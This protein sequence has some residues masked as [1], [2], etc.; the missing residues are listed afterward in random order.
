MWKK[1]MDF[2]SSVPVTVIGGIL[3]VISLVLSL[4][5]TAVPVDPAWVTVVLCGI[6][7]AEQAV[8]RIVTAK[9]ISRI[10]SSLLI[11]IAMCAAVAA[12]DV[13]AAG[14]VAFI[15]AIGTILENKT[16]NR[17]RKGVER[18]VDLTPR[19]GRR[20]VDGREEMVNTEDIL[21]GDVLRVLPGETIPV[22]GEILTG[23]TSVDQS[24]M[25]GESVPVDKEPGDSVFCGTMNQ[26]GAVEIRATKVGEDSS[27]QT[28]IRM[29]RQAEADK[30]PV[31][32]IADQ[33]ASWMV[34]LSLLIAVVT[35]IITRDINRSVAVLVVFCPCALVLATPTAVMAAIGQAA[36]H[37]VLVKSGA[38]LEG[39]AKS[40]T[41]T[42]DKTGTLTCGQLEVSDV[43]VTGGR[44]DPE[45]ALGLTASAELDSEHP[46][47]KAI[48]ASARERGLDPEK[49][50]C[51]EMEAG[52]GVSAV[53]GG[54]KL[55]CGTGRYL[56]EH[57]I[58]VPEKAEKVLQKIRNQGK[59]SVLT[60]C[61]GEVVCVIALSDTIRPSAASVVAEL[62][63]LHIRSVLLT[64]DNRLAAGYFAARTGIQTVRAELLPADKVESISELQREGHTVCMIGDGVN[65]SPALK[66]ADVGIAM[67]GSGS[68]IAVEA[69][70]VTLIGDD[71]TR[72]PYLKRLSQSMLRTIWLGIA[73]AMAINLVAVAL[74][75]TGLMGPTVGALV[76]NAGSILVVL[77]AALLYDRDPSKGRGRDK[78]PKPPV[79]KS[80]SSEDL[81]GRNAA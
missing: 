19:Q 17:A 24:I 79:R 44:M 65:D 54:R 81:A 16:A 31:Q 76:H 23:V 21:E 26:F 32:R 70:D 46:L 28:M 38:A 40:D 48:V 43:I 49:P 66:T 68:D 56:A 74:S 45:A 77:L 1:I 42:F 52:K 69:A 60:A 78:A 75:V 73:I 10:S 36:K 51:F 71:I 57:G 64:G 4:T 62:A 13:F 67:G 33:C 39:I 15:M 59:A 20:I 41:F 55:L 63:S 22:D 2:L 47:G 25:T 12:G 30:A 34:P 27:L 72:L 50:E 80:G 14:E 7:N 29:V 5:E 53:V 6:P 3:L 18:L 37:G 9:G 58:T 8:R 61:D 35:A 11:T